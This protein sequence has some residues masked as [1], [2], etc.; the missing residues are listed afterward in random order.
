MKLS[1]FADVCLRTVMVL[2]APG[3]GQLTSREISESVG[4]PYNHVAKAVLK[5]RGLG[6]LEVTRGRNGGATL[7]TDALSYSLG[8][9]LRELD[10]RTDVVDCSEH[11]AQANCPLIGDCRLRSVL[12]TAREAFY[13]SLDPL[14]IQDI[15]PTS[16]TFT[17]LPF[18]AVRTTP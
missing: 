5:L 1:A 3:V 16:A 10:Q 12:G 7:A 13:A 4:I 6:I 9:L 15:C 11:D 8:S 14:T 2:A 17:A 18:P